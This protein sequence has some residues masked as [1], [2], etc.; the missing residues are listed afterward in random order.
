MKDRIKDLLREVLNIPAFRLPQQIKVS[1][2]DLSRLKSISYQDI[3]INDF[4]GEG[5]IAHL[6]VSFPFETNASDGIIIDIQI[7]Q[8]II[9][10]LHLQLSDSLQG[11]G[12]GGKIAKAVINEFG[13]IYSGKGR[14]L[15]PNA[16]KMLDNIKND[17]NFV[18]I[19]NDRGEL[20]MMKDNPDEEKLRAFMA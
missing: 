20:Y 18:Y 1:Q 4:G 17:P 14:V 3:M 9:Y 19:P 15:N 16:E 2:E 5:N 7:L 12:L 8:G 10:Q 11:I 6:G 13:H